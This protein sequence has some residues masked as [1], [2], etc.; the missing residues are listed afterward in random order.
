MKIHSSIPRGDSRSYPIQV[1][2]LIWSAGST[3]FFAMKSIVDDDPLDTEA[4]VVKSFTD[5]DIT[6]QDADVVQYQMDLVPADTFDLA[7]GSYRAEFQMVSADEQTVVTFPDP[8]KDV[9]LFAVTGDVNR[10]TA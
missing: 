8:G 2:A 7:L 3:L 5:A 4:V 10:R 6:A 9:W 1:P